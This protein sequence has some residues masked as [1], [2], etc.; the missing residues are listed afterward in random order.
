MP[1]AAKTTGCLGRDSTY[2]GE[3]RS[4]QGHGPEPPPPASAAAWKGRNGDCSVP[5]PIVAE[6]ALL[7]LVQVNGAGWCLVQIRRGR[8]SGHLII[9]LLVAR[10]GTDR[11]CRESAE[12]SRSA[13]GRRHRGTPVTEGPAP[14]TA[15]P[16]APGPRA[17]GKKGRARTG[18]G[19][20]TATRSAPSALF[21]T[22]A[23]GK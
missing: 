11:S 13:R 20:R 9:R 21:T 3:S 10:G 12:G 5:D 1:T 6:L 7:G 17:A 8:G 2:C 18:G 14:A 22:A 23:A 19:R 16:A 4:G 15:G